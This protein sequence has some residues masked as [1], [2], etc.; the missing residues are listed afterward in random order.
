MAARNFAPVRALDRDVILL[1]GG[2]TG[3]GAAALTAILGAGV[4]S[5]AET[6]TGKYTITFRD[7]FNALLYF[8]GVVIDPGTPDDWEVV[9]E[10]Y[11]LSSKTI[12][13]VV[14]KGG[15]AADLTT[16]E[17]LK[18]MAVFSNTAQA[19]TAR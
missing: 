10:S 6:A 5:V 2:G 1:F 16:D 19:P 17:K 13:I 7:K 18:F 11:S 8:Q 4:A 12:S 14:F 9:V 15:T 3:A